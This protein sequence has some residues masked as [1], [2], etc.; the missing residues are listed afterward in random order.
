MQTI[1]IKRDGGRGFRVIN[2]RD[3]DPDVHAKFT[4]KPMTKPEVKAA[5]DALGLEYDAK[6]RV[7]DLRAMLERAK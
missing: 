7:Q 6:A 3:F 4:D 2:A 5:L 1:K